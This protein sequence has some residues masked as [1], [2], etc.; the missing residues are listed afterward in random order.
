[1]PPRRTPTPPVTYPY[2]T[3]QDAF[4]RV[5]QQRKCFER[6]LL[7]KDFLYVF[8]SG[9]NIEAYEIDFQKSEYLHLTGMDYRGH[10]ATNV[11]RQAQGL[12][13]VP[14]EAGNFYA[15]LESGDSTLVNDMSF[16]GA[17]GTRVFNYTQDKLQHLPQMIMLAKKAESIIECD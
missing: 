13:P 12:P 14:T 15:R 9:S 7:E 1:M 17:T 3:V 5:A 2:P 10:Y 11:Q 6:E 8:C 16:K 4:R